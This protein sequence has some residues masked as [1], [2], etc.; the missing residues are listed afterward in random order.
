MKLLDIL[1]APY[2]EKKK[3]EWMTERLMKLKLNSKYGKLVSD[4]KV[5]DK[6]D[7][8]YADTDSI[9]HNLVHHEYSYHMTDY[10]YKFKHNS[11]N[12]IAQAQAVFDFQKQL[13]GDIISN[14]ESEYNPKTMEHIFHFDIWT[15]Q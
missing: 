15:R 5:T 4:L 13:T 12:M 11:D 2:L 3:E 9:H 6:H 8:K 7:F 1:L 10:E 14:I